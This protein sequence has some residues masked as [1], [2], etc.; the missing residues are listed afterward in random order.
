MKKTSAKIAKHIMSILHEVAQQR[1]SLHNYM[2]ETIYT[3]IYMYIIECL[4]VYRH[5]LV[6][7]FIFRDIHK[8]I[9]KSNYVFNI[10]TIF[11]YF[12][13]LNIHIYSHRNRKDIV[14]FLY[15]LQFFDVK[16]KF[17][18]DCSTCR[19]FATIINGYAPSR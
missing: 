17:S 6:L 10:I 18:R 7:V 3:C 2:Y 8:F 11:L 13:F 5:I 19:H 15:F 12:T 4:C 9:L 1:A 14:A 16:I